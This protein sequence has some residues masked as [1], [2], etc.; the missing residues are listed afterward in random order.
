MEYTTGYE[1][2][3]GGS[4]DEYLQINVTFMTHGSPPISGLTYEDIA[5]SV[6]ELL[7]G[8]GGVLNLEASRRYE[9]SE[10]FDPGV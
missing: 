9:G 5:S 6:Y 8:H 10:T 1:F 7:D 3:A 2:R 4:G